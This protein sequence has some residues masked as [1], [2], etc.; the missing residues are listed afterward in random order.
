MR[1]SDA[2]H[3]LS[4][5][6]LAVSV[7]DWCILWEPRSDQRRNSS[8]VL[9]LSSP[10]NSSH[11]EDKVCKCQKMLPLD[12]GFCTCAADVLTVPSLW[13]Q[14][15][16]DEDIGVRVRVRVQKSKVSDGHL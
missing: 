5:C 4:I 15:K 12:I 6:T 9:C 10:G 16:G 8:E 7:L 11:W 1:L 14:V 2:V 13:F 3:V